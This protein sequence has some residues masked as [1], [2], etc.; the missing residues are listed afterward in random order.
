[1]LFSHSVQNSDCHCDTQM[2]R[3][4][5]FIVYKRDGSRSTP[6]C[7][8]PP[9]RHPEPFPETL[10]TPPY[11][12]KNSCKCSPK[13]MT[14]V[15]LMVLTLAL[16]MRPRELAR[17]QS[18]SFSMV[19]RCRFASVSGTAHMQNAKLT[20]SKYREERLVGN[21][22]WHPLPLLSGQS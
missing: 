14:K 12:H 13:T 20:C 9:K 15:I 21:G 10:N 18:G 1:M 8:S 16:G 5:A 6:H 3:K 2:K 7:P 17:R 11:F 19:I 22:H 4:G